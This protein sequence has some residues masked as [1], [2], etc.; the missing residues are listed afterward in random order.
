MTMHHRLF[1]RNF[2]SKEKKILFRMNDFISCPSPPPMGSFDTSIKVVDEHRLNTASYKIA[3]DDR[4][5]V[6]VKFSQE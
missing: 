2:K 1:A 3:F 6:K 5:L 4:L